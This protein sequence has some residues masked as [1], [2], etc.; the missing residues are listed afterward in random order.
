MRR[1]D[2]AQR[3]DRVLILFTTFGYFDDDGNMQVVENVAR[4]LRPGGLLGFDI[5]NRDLTLNVLPPCAVV[6]KEDNLMINRNSFD[7]VTGRWHN[8]RIVI[9]D[10]VRKDKPFS[11]RLYNPAEIR[12]L[13]SGAGLQV[14]AIYGDWDAQPLSTDSRGMV[15]ITEKPASMLKD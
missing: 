11:I 12:S 14:R 15:V 2:F 8:R 9:R 5:P 10:G 1:L 6:E 4:A 7:T 13:V 3:F